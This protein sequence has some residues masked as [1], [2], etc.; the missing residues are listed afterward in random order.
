MRKSLLKKILLPLLLAEQQLIGGQAVIEGV[1]MKSNNY[2]SVSVRKKDKKIKTTTKKFVS[3]T[4]RNKMLGLPFIRGVVTL[5]ETLILGYKTLIQS[6]NESLDEDDKKLSN[7]ELIITM[8]LATL[9]FIV[10][11]KLIPLGIASIS[12]PGNTYLFNIIEGIAKI[13]IL[14]LYLVVISKMSDVK[15]LF[16]YHG[17][18]H[19]TIDC[20]E[21][22]K[23][24]T[25]ANVKRCS[26]EHMRC[27]TTFIL[28]VLLF[29][30][31]VYLIVPMSYNFWLKLALRLALLPVI[32]GI[33]YEIIRLAARSR[34]RV[35]KII[36]TP[37]LWLQ[38]LTTRE[39]DA[40]QIETAIASFNAV[41]AKE[42]R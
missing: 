27:G 15:T 20:Y 32:A 24:L 30:I 26:K 21:R 6:A 1:M 5:V 39:P 12:K 29:S 40:R 31:I 2:F 10:L 4:K 36:I 19:K 25:V 35:L 16:R 34:S 9:I 13:A 42:R 41:L 11:F 38:S 14:I 8:A 3:W 17:A 33:S 28:F 7:F 37:G 22:K 18:E 23:K